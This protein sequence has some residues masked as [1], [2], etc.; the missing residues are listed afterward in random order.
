MLQGAGRSGGARPSASPPGA[1]AD[2]VTFR[3]DLQRLGFPDSKP[4][5]QSIGE[6]TLSEDAVTLFPWPFITTISERK[7]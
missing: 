2:G 7:P 3:S 6:R 5:A 1:M 4:G